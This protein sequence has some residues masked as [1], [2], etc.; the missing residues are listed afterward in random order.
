MK[1]NLLDITPDDVRDYNKRMKL[2]NDNIKDVLESLKKETVDVE[3]S[4]R[5]K[6]FDI[7]QEEIGSQKQ[8]FEKLVEVLDDYLKYVDRVVEKGDELRDTMDGLQK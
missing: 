7:L 2:L 5:G 1:Q 6:Y 8:N 4:F 3:D